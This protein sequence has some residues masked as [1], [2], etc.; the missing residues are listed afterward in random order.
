M[1]RLRELTLVLIKDLHPLV[2]MVQ[3]STII[4]L[5]GYGVRK[6]FLESEATGTTFKEISKSK[7]REIQI[8]LPPLAEQKRIVS[9]IESIF[10]RIDAIERYMESTLRLLDYL[11]NRHAQ[12]GL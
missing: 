10:T 4:L 1:L 9:R 2:V 8:P 11:K 5:T 12:A 3:C 6:N 7:L